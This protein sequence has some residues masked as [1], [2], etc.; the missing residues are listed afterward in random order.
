[1]HRRA[2]NEALKAAIKHPKLA[3]VI[4][5]LHELEGRTRLGDDRPQF[6]RFMELRSPEFAATFVPRIER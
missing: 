3:P 2:V 6:E 1:M 4:A 5:E